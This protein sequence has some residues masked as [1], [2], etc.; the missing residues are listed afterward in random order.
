[1]YQVSDKNYTIF[2]IRLVTREK[3]THKDMLSNQPHNNNQI[4]KYTFKLNLQ[5]KI[6]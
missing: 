2:I 6:C 1:M 4:Q 5:I 3:M